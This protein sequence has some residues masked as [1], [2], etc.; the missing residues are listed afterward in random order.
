MLIDIIKR[1]FIEARKNRDTEKSLLLSTL[2]GEMETKSVIDDGKKCISD[3]LAVSTVKKFVK[4]IDDTLKIKEDVALLIEKS[5]LLTYLPKNLSEKE[6]TDI[7]Q[8]AIDDGKANIGALMGH[9][10]TN[11]ANQYDGKLASQLVNKLLKK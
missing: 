5:I 1:D 6:L 2:I 8:N 7:I 4:N 9:L 10:K 3:D 11:Y